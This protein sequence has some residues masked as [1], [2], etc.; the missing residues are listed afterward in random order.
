MHVTTTIFLLKQAENMFGAKF[1]VNYISCHNTKIAV[2]TYTCKV[3]NTNI[4]VEQIY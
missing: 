1:G 2:I 3:I 4:I